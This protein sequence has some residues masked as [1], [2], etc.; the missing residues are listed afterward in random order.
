[1]LFQELN[2]NDQKIKVLLPGASLT[3]YPQFLTKTT[4]NHCLTS[5]LTEINWQSQPIKIFGKLVMQPRLMAWYGNP[6]VPIKY[7]G[8]T[9]LPNPWTATLLALKDKIEK[10]LETEFNGVL[11]NLYRN[12]NDSMGWH[13][14]DESY[15]GKLP[16]IP[17][18]SLGAERVFQLKHKAEKNLSKNLVL[19]H[20]SLLL[21]QGE[22]QTH[23]KHQLPKTKRITEPR[24]NLTFRQIN[25]S[26]L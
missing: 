12:G 9:F 10:H 2:A 4:A 3:Y 16:T 8:V 1:M 25:P 11:C 7:S 14:D 13:S 15:L 26:L 5:L 22:T 20:G 17:S 24:I 21:M 19:E 6:D 18:L 23:Y